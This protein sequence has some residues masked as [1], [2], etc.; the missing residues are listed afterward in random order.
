MQRGDKLIPFLLKNRLGPVGTIRN[1]RVRDADWAP[2]VPLGDYSANPD[3][4]ELGRRIDVS[5]DSDAGPTDGRVALIP[6]EKRTK[7]AVALHTVEEVSAARFGELV[8]ILRD[9]RTWITLRV[10]P[11][12]PPILPCPP[13]EAL[14]V[15]ERDL[16]RFL[17]RNLDRIEPG[18]KPTSE[19]QLEE[20]IADPVGR[21][22]LFC[23]DRSGAYV[24]VELKTGT[25]S[26][27]VIGQ[28]AGYMSWVKDNVAK[29]APVR[30]IIICRDAV[31][32]VRAASKLI[33]GL[34]IKKYSMTFTVEELA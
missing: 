33:P 10:P 21:L 17:A 31:P 28:I 23:Q 13:E 20:Q 30:G 29:S 32:S 27:D 8:E 22:D 15:L 9:Q 11:S 34:T 7:K 6:P 1:L 26:N 2:T 24:V 14:S 5:W 18:L 16:Q 25:A 3:E 19:Y 12:D 4:P